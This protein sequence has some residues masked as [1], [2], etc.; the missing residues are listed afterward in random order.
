[1]P[2]TI[3]NVDDHEINRYVRTQVLQQAG[4][5]VIEAATGE[6]AISKWASE[7]PSLVLLDVNLPDMNGL[8]VC[9]RI[10]ANSSTRTLVIHVSATYIETADQASGLQGGADGYLCEPVDPELLVATVGS[11]LR[12]R[13]AEMKLQESQERLTQAQTIAGLTFWEWD[14]A[15][16]RVQQSGDVHSGPSEVSFEEWLSSVHVE[17]RA[18]VEQALRGARCGTESVRCEFRAHTPDGSVRWL[19]TKGRVFCDAD[20]RPVRI[21][22]TDMEITERKRIELAV[23]RSNED[24]SMFAFMISH[25]LQEPLRTI[26]TFTEMLSLKHSAVL[27]E[28][29][30]TYLSYVA[31]GSRRMNLMIT[32]LLSFCNI[33]ETELASPEPVSL[34]GVL[35]GVLANVSTALEESGGAITHDP[36]PVVLGDP[37]QLAEIFQNLVGNALK[38]RMPEA[39]P[40]IHISAVRGRNVWT[41]SVTDNGIG[42]DQK[43]AEEI[44]NMFKRLHGREIHGSGIGLAVVKKI[45]ERHGGRIWAESHAGEGSRFSFTLPASQ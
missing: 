3:L 17:D 18:A 36:L 1:M 21:I 24:L 4:Y 35:S 25:D 32:E 34:E 11:F 9:R 13:E 10:K 40:R 45:V 31:E 44:F 43:H 42:F 39:P 37:A 27:N 5:R 33:Q 28:E 26:T 6:D 19:A 15:R 2:S 20:G 29:A 22:G 12:L 41:V 38:Y 23:K 14:I 7:K 16:N 30:A 8:Q